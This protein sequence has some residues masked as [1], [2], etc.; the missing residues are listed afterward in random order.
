MSAFQV[1]EYQKKQKRLR[2]CILTFH[3]NVDF[4]FTHGVPQFVPGDDHQN[5]RQQPQILCL[6][7]IW[8]LVWGV[9]T[10]NYF[11]PT[12][13]LQ[14]RVVPKHPAI[15]LASTIASD[16]GSL[17]LHYKHCPTKHQPLPVIHCHS[18]T[19]SSPKTSCSHG[20]GAKG[21]LERP[22]S[23][24]TDPMVTSRRNKTDPR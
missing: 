7:A 1:I 14:P 12:W 20:T 21:S 10:S 6:L 17:P 15:K 16:V 23:E 9:L 11:E 5:P 4:L 2:L 3:I 18:P 24:G 13:A 22:G 19:Y 8:P